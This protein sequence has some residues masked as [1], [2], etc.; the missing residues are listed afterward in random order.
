MAMVNAVLFTGN[1]NISVTEKEVGDPGSGE[2]RLGLRAAGVCGSDLHFLHMSPAERRNPSLGAGLEGDPAI[3]P[4]HEIAGVVEAVG[5]GVTNVQVGTRVAVQHYSGCGDCR[6]CRMGWDPLCAN[7][8]IYT[9]GRDG[10]FQDEVLAK[11]RDCLPIPD[12]MSYAAGAFIACG[13]GTSFQAVRRGELKAGDT[14]VA[15]GLGPVGLSALLWGLAEG[16][17]IIGIDPNPERRDFARSLGIATTLDPLRPDLHEQ[18][19]AITGRGGAD[20]VIETAGNT[21]GRRLALEVARPW[22]TVVFVSFGP[23][24]ELDAAQHIVQKQITLRGS[25]MFSVSTM[26][27]A[28]NFAQQ[29]G[30]DLDQV[31]TRTCTLAEAPQ[32]I[33][34]FDAGAS[35]KT[36]IAWEES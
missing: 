6:E 20:V 32:A 27:D 25:W 30:V 15:V 1:G 35:G 5:A 24:C 2:V 12:G 9:L 10:G 14:L 28:M 16:A 29:R 4:G 13:A 7:K 21:P 23:G 19:E 26:M 8:T 3:T 18:I 11:S 36:V 22:G 17:R 31:V 34:D 33:R